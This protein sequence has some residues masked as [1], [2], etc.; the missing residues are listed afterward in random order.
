MTILDNV[1]KLCEENGITINGLE[2]AG[3]VTRGSLA[4]WDKTSPGIDKVV[5]VAHYFHV[6]IDRLLEGTKYEKPADLMADGL[7]EKYAELIALFN[8]LSDDQ[9]DVVLAQLRG[10][11]QLQKAPGDLSISE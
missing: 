4:K 7:D 6:P 2:K 3:V 9:K 8:S 5:S 1:K 10:L 11:M